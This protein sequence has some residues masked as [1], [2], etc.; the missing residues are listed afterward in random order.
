MLL[1]K[2]RG[3]L[4]IA[5]ES[6]KWLGQVEM[7]L[8]VDVAGAESKVLYCKEQYCIGTWNVRSMNQRRLDMAKQEMERLE[9]RYLRN[10]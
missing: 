8:V 7:T 4:L 10:Q 6:M 9:H 3:Q 2:S 1:G 5:P